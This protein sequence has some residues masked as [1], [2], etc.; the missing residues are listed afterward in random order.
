MRSRSIIMALVVMLVAPLPLLAQQGGGQRGGMGGGALAARVLLEQGSVEFIAS[1][2]AELKLTEEQA[3]AL[4]A[5][6]ARWTE[7]TKASRAKIAA[8]MPQAGDMGGMGGMGGG[9]R[10]ALMQ[11]FQ[12]LAPMMQK[13]QEDD[14]TAMAEAMK[15]L[16]ETQQVAA[17]RMVDERR[18]PQRRPGG[19]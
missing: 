19:V 15:L 12:A 3:T 1:K 6:G 13:L 9:N 4:T 5:I 16:D 14:A 7:E 8:G 17:R 10:E 11:R 2:A 18:M